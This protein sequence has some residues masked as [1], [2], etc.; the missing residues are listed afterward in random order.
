M[1]AA[2]AEASRGERL[3][4][5]LP[6]F[7]ALFQRGRCGQPDRFMAAMTAGRLDGRV[8]IV[9]GAGRGLGR[10]YAIALARHGAAVIVNDLGGDL[11]GLGRDAS[12][13]QAVVAEIEAAG[14]RAA[15]SGH[16]VS[17]WADAKAL[18]SMS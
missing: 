16:D 12:P 11:H 10:A 13:S 7:G 18:V 8:A 4:P 5:R 17:D 9:T 15:V 14:G 3:V 1:S 2:S 6:G